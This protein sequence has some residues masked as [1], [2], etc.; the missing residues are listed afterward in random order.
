MEDSTLIDLERHRLQLETQVAQLRKALQTWQLWSAEYEGLKEEIL[1]KHNPTTEDLLQI[2]RDFNGEVISVVEIDDILNLKDTPRAANQVVDLLDKRLEYVSKNVVD[3]GKMLKAAEEKFEKVNMV[4]E[5]LESGGKDDEGLPVTE[6]TEELDDDDNVISFKTST[7]GSQKGQL[8]DVL[9]KAGVTEKDLADMAMNGAPKQKEQP[10]PAPKP[11]IKKAQERKPHPLSQVAVSEKELLV[12]DEIPETM[13]ETLPGITIQKKKGVSFSG[14]TKPGPDVVPSATQQKIEAIMSLAK[15][16]NE[17]IP[18]DG[19]EAPIIPDEDEEDARMR[20]EM[21]AY[22]MSEMGSVVAELELEDGSD[23]DEDDY[24]DSEISEE[25]EFGRSIRPV[26]D[27]D[28]HK[29]M[30]ELE[31]K[32]GVRG[33]INVGSNPEPD[34]STEKFTPEAGM[35]QIKITQEDIDAQAKIAREDEL[36][37]GFNNMSLD[38]SASDL[39]SGS[40]AKDMKVGAS[41]EELKSSF[42]ETKLDANG[43][44]VTVAAK[45]GVRFNEE[46]D[47]SPAPEVKKPELPVRP[48][49]PAVAPISDIVERKPLEAIAPAAPPAAPAKKVSKFKAARAGPGPAAPFVPPTFQHARSERSVPSGPENATLATKI[50][51]RDSIPSENAAEPDEL[52]AGLLQQEVA[53]EYHKR[54]ND[55]I[56]K[57]GGFTAPRERFAA[58]GTMLDEELFEADGKPVKKMSRFMAARLAK[59]AGR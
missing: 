10:K 12:A 57:E 51:E 49:V 38:T 6:I 35:A 7:P 41:E 14:D 52:D 11:A 37:S 33:L 56:M 48:K 24:T 9:K 30:R 59:E 36:A 31:E 16:Q 44:V 5:D 23:W 26:V 18:S 47:I 46:L 34:V 20:R 22:G 15:H 28:M 58:D 2:G 25:D 29:R 54:R 8:L 3:T 53:M 39:K 43:N 4:Q 13:P 55:M 50:V 40:D 45:K 21:L 27:E 42:K 17:P 32:L 19:P 1:E